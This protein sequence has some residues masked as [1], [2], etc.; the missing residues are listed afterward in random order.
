MIEIDGGSEDSA[1][2]QKVITFADEANRNVFTN[3][4]EEGT[5]TLPRFYA[6]SIDGYLYESTGR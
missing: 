4:G 1:V 5:S 6:D 2:G 3:H